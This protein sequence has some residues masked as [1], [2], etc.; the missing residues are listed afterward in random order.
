MTAE[1][2]EFVPR[3]RPAIGGNGLGE[4]GIQREQ[5]D[6]DEWRRLVEHFVGQAHRNSPR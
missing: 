6:I 3:A 1:F 5:I 2:G 4:R